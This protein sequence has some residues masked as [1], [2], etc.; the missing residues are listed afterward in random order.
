MFVNNMFV[1][2]IVNKNTYVAKQV[3]EKELQIFFHWL[4]VIVKHE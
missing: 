4:N 3:L 1:K 2:N